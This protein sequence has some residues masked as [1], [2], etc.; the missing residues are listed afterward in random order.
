MPRWSAKL[1]RSFGLDAWIDPWV[2]SGEIGLRKPSPM[3][4]RA[5]LDRLGV[6]ASDVLVVDD[7]PKNLDAARSEGFVTALFDRDGGKETAHR[8]IGS[9]EDLLNLI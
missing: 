3:I 5:L 6:P 9:L 1:R 7:R 2:I 8:R 4:Y